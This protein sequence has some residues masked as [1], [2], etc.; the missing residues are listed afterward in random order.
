MHGMHKMQLQGHAHDAQM[1]QIGEMRLIKGLIA[2]LTRFNATS[3]FV[4][5]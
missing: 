5:G 3:V 1:R 4:A 2:T